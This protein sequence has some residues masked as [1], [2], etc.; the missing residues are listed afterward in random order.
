VE[1]TVRELY[2]PKR[3]HTN[4]PEIPQPYNTFAETFSYGI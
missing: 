4:A 3:P 2:T 1:K